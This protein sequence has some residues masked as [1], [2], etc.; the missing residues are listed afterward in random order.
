MYILSK[1]Y[2]KQL[3]EVARKYKVKKDTIHYYKYAMWKSY[4]LINLTE[5]K[6]WKL[7]TYSKNNEV[8]LNRLHNYIIIWVIKH[9]VNSI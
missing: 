8:A 7:R 6:Q 1:I 2:Y 3:K 5:F 9:N 4:R